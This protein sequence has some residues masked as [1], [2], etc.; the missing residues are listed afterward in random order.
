MHQDHPNSLVIYP[1]IDEKQARSNLEQ[2]LSQSS[3]IASS[4]TT[5]S[6]SRGFFSSLFHPSKPKDAVPPPSF[7][8]FL[9]S[10]NNIPHGCAKLIYKGL[11]FHPG[12]EGETLRLLEAFVP[13]LIEGLENARRKINSSTSPFPVPL[14]DS[15]SSLSIVSFQIEEPLLEYRPYSI[16]VKP[17]WIHVKD[18]YS[19]AVYRARTIQYPELD[20]FESPVGPLTLRERSIASTVALAVSRHSTKKEFPPTPHIMIRERLCEHESPI[21]YV[22]QYLFPFTINHTITEIVT[23]KKVQVSQDHPACIEWVISGSFYSVGGLFLDTLDGTILDI[24]LMHLYFDPKGKQATV[25]SLTMNG[26][27]ILFPSPTK[28]P[29]GPDRDHS[30]TREYLG[31]SAFLGVGAIFFTT[32]FPPLGILMGLGA[33]WGGI[34]GAWSY[35]SNR[36]DVNEARQRYQ[37]LL[38]KINSDWKTANQFLKKER[39]VLTYP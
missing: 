30:K 35:L 12:S 10:R 6:S 22:P 31:A 14:G 39:I 29:S 27:G 37:T 33:G 26:T 34:E 15:K 21:I 24:A 20:G 11:G 38:A 4:S 19:G 7:S 5:K 32:L 8:L 3:P 13:Y 2:H 23:S 36:K 17:E 16:T 18:L 1:L 25:P 9:E 28:L